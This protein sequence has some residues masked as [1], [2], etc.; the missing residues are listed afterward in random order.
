MN[1]N[2]HKKKNQTLVL[3]VTIHLTNQM[4]LKIDQFWQN[5][6]YESIMKSINYFSSIKI[7]NFD[8]FNLN[9]YKLIVTKI[10]FS[11][12]RSFYTNIWRMMLQFDS[13]IFKVEFNFNKK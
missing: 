7:L 13:N 3:Q 10:R 5:K 9:Q 12:H 2:P 4:I 1:L 8:N 6:L 11:N